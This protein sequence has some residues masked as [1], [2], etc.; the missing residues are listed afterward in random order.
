MR[1]PGAPQ[2]LRLSPWLLTL[3]GLCSFPRKDGFE[4][5]VDGDVGKGKD[6]SQEINCP[7]YRI[8]LAEAEEGE[9]REAP[10]HP[11]DCIEL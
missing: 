10:A 11:N 5:E 9:W 4:E 7:E 3:L 2:T 1:S 6:I 8:V